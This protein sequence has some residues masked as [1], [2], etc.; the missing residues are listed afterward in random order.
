MCGRF[1]QLTPPAAVAALFCIDGATGLPNVPP[2][3]NA[4]PTQDL[5]VIRRHPD[6][7][8]RHLDLM[9]WGLVPSF[10]PDMSGGA[11]LINARAET[12][13]SKPTFRA[14]WKARRCIV[15]ADFF[16]EWKAVEGRRQPFLI[17]RADGRPMAFAG[18][19][20]GW[21]DP[22][23]GLWQRTFTILT[24]AADP[25]LVPLHERMPVILGEEDIAAFLEAP[26]PRDLMRPFPGLVLRPVSAR[27]NA[28]RND[29]ADLLAPLPPAEAEAALAQLSA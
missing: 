29:D 20:E 3:Y 13:P 17:A 16:Y 21:R 10:A 28:V 22:A 15:P 14:A 25:A 12:A 4:A 26:D 27:V 24:C 5:M 9:R 7:G 8:A 19:W 18:L 1:V 2:R 6:S 11:K 23:T